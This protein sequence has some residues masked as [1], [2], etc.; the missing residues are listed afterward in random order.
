MN[1]YFRWQSSLVASRSISTSL[2]RS[3]KPRNFAINIT[4]ELT[5]YAVYAANAAITAR[6][7]VQ[8]ARTFPKILSKRLNLGFFGFIITAIQKGVEKIVE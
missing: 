6:F 3:L 7:A 2:E 5:Y 8:S 1:Y 4:L